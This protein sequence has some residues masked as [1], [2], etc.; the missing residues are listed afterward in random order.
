VPHEPVIAALRVLRQKD[1]EVRPELYNEILSKKTKTK[2]KNRI[3][4]KE[5]LKPYSLGMGLLPEAMPAPQP[6][7]RLV[8]RIRDWLE[9]ELCV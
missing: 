4:T 2:C 3:E 7:F 5:E 1:C 8:K 9:R 6:M